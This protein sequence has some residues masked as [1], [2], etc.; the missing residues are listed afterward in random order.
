MN[1]YEILRIL[2]KGNY[3]SVVLASRPPSGD[4]SP[5]NYNEKVGSKSL[6]VIKSVK[7]TRKRDGA[8]VDAIKEVHILKDLKHPC[9]VEYIDSFFNETETRLFIAMA[10]CDSGNLSD[11]IKSAIEQQQWIPE[12]KL[13]GGS[14]SCRWPWLLYTRKN[15]V[16]STVMSSRKMYF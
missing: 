14:P 2:G 15:L 13:L 5:E 11:R 8:N 1:G 16:Y 9:I 12:E 3:G 10:Y 6:C 4:F 7:H